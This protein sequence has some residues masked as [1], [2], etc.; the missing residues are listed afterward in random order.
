MHNRKCWTAWLMRIAFG[1]ACVTILSMLPGCQISS[2]VSEFC[3]LYKPVKPTKQERAALSRE[4]TLDLDG[5]NAVWAER[6][7]K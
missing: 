5:N 4:T 6:C 3:L 2:P 7:K 1:L